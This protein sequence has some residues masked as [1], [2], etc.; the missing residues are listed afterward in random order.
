MVLLHIPPGWFKP[1]L[2]VATAL[3]MAAPFAPS[4]LAC[5]QHQ[6]KPLQIGSPLK[7]QTTQFV[8][9]DHKGMVCMAIAPQCMTK[10]QWA[11][12][13]LSNKDGSANLVPN[14]KSK[15]ID[16]QSCRDALDESAP[17]VDF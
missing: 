4:A 3:T 13:C 5:E 10:K 7:E 14:S 16:S 17:N 8:P 9:E 12:H 15:L 6:A 11:A 2:G 1:A